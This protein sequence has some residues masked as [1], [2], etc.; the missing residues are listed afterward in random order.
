MSANKFKS[1][2]KYTHPQIGLQV[3][4]HFFKSEDAAHKKIASLK[5]SLGSYPIHSTSVEERGP[6]GKWKSR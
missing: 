6:D 5:R 1:V 4:Q 3:S 2:V